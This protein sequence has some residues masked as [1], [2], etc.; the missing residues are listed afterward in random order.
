[1]GSGTTAISASEL[2]RRYIGFELNK[3]YQDMAI[4]R[5]S[6]LVTLKEFI[7]ETI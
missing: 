3:I 6:E 1:M 2:N 5:L 4:K 7:D